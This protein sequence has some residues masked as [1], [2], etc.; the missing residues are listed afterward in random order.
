MEIALILSAITLGFTSGFHCLGMCGPIAMSMGISKKQSSN[1]YLQNFIYQLGRITTYTL[2]G[3]VF[4]IVG[5]GFQLAGLQ[6]TLTVFAGIILIL[7]SVTSF[8]GTDFATKIPFLSKLLFQVKIKLGTLLSQTGY[9][10]RFL[11]GVLNGLLPCGM[12]YMALTASLAA[13][14]MWK[15]TTFMALF[16]LGTFPFMFVAVAF[17]NILTVVVRTQILKFVPVLMLIL[18]GL[19]VLRGLDIGIPYVSPKKEM[20]QVGKME[21]DKSGTEKSGKTCH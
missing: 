13:G 19:F 10:S 1:F 9:S 2:L 12:V 6:Q 5:E 4:G 3:L 16:G 17:G 15:S 7:M 14:D 11:T 18:G 21:M 20:L 8:R